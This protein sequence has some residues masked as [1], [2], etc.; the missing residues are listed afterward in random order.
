MPRTTPRPVRRRLWSLATGELVSIVVL[1]WV[2]YGLIGLPLSPAN[3]LGT[4]LALFVLLQGSV[5]W[6]L[7]LRRPAAPRGMQVYAVL[8]WLNPVLLAVALPPLVVAVVN[9]P[10]DEAIAGLVFWVL[11]VLEHVNYFH[12]Q[13][14]YDNATDLRRLRTSG[15]QRA[16]LGLDIARR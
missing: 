13:L 16:H 4:A 5:Y 9:G 7:K 6:L 8:R 3:V 12:T 11:A 15:L 14:M 10:A 2:A 1:P